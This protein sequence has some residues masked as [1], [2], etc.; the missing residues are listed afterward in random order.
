M[1]SRVVMF[2]S[3]D[4]IEHFPLKKYIFVYGQP[5]VNKTVP[6]NSSVPSQVPS[7]PRSQKGKL[8]MKFLQLD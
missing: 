1:F 2:V 5:R 8:T 7:G 6:Q 3:L 4:S